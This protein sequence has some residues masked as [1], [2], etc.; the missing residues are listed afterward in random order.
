MWALYERTITQSNPT[1][2]VSEYIHISIC[3]LRESTK[4]LEDTLKAKI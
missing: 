2:L 1:S 4:V 3:L